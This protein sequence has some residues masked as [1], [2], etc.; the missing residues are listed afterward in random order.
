[1]NISVE[2]RRVGWVAKA[3]TAG[4]RPLTCTIRYWEDGRVGVDV[5]D[6]TYAGMNSGEVAERIADYYIAD[7]D[8]EPYP[9]DEHDPEK[10]QIMF[11]GVMEDELIYHRPVGL[12]HQR[13]KGWTLLTD[14]IDE[15]LGEIDIFR[16]RF[17]QTTTP[18]LGGESIADVLFS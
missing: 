15:L 17:E 1:M 14:S 4:G 10:G 8:Q 12:L 16:Q 6:A 5:Y 13:H 9:L 3:T 7:Y 18:P 2:D 11:R